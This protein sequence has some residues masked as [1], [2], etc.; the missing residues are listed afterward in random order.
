[1]PTPAAPRR[2]RRRRKANLTPDQVVADQ[3][4]ALRD[5]HG[6]SQQQLA[7]MIGET[8]STIARIESGQ[9]TISI[10]DLFRLAAALDVAP[11]YL[12]AGQFNGGRVPVR[13]GVQLAPADAHEWIVG[14]KPL[15]GGDERAYIETNVPDELFELRRK[16]IE[17]MESLRRRFPRGV[18]LVV[19]ADEAPSSGPK[20]EIKWDQEESE[21][22]AS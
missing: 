5:K 21:S 10:T 8:Q 13:A 22:D 17:N 7:E 14:E 18:A 3:I 16:M 12:L 2:T 15:P 19:P 4:R 1:M 6:I 11:V 20:I 9:R